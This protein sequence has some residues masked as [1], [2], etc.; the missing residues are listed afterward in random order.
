MC[1]SASLPAFTALL[2]NVIQRS[3]FTVY[4]LSHVQT[5]LRFKQ[6]V[7][8]TAKRPFPLVR[9]SSLVRREGVV[10]GHGGSRWGSASA[11]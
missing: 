9:L 6:R 1:I 4:S 7:L 2:A 11:S 10:S 3:V 5:P 8:E